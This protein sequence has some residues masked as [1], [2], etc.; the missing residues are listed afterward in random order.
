MPA[1]IRFGATAAGAEEYLPPPEK[2]LAGNPRQWVRNHYTDA[3]A[4]FSAGEWRCEV[5]KWKI[6]YTEEEFCQIIE[7]V[8]IVTDADGKAVTLV[9]GDRLVIPRGF[10]GTW[11][12]VE[13]TRK[14]YVIYEP[15]L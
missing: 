10:T 6:A 7:G 4:K 14:T 15:G 12:V 11:E 2:V 8:S 5:G 13:P 9:S 3:S 1:I